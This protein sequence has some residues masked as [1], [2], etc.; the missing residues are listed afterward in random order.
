VANEKQSQAAAQAK[1]DKS[2]FFFGVVR[3]VDELGVLIRE[4][5][6]RALEA[7]TVLAQIGCCLIGIPLEFERL[8]SVRTLY[9]RC[10]SC[11]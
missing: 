5:R 7:H 6:L 10:N 4:G 11:A 2:I 3:V 1:Q 8:V 9:I